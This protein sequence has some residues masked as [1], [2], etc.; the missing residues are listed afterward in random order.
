MAKRTFSEFVT[1]S[2]CN[3][4]FQELCQEILLQRS[5]MQRLADEVRE[6]RT[7]VVPPT[8][9]AGVE[10]SAGEHP[11]LLDGEL[12]RACKVREP[13]IFAGD[14]HEV[15]DWLEDMKEYSQ[16]TGVSESRWLFVSKSYPSTTLKKWVHRK[17]KSTTPFRSFQD[18]AEALK[19]R[20]IDPLE[21]DHCRDTLEEL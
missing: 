12:P 1:Q 10:T 4:Q 11:L 17:Q 3:A 2:E 21:Q 8:M 15:S 16:G 19:K 5:V 18:F 14:W 7:Q 13:F 20:Y 9:A 6:P